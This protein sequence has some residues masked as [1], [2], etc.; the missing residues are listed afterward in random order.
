MNLVPN[1]TDIRNNILTQE[2]LPLKKLRPK[3]DRSENLFDI[4][5]NLPSA[6]ANPQPCF[7]ICMLHSFK[8]NCITCRRSQG[9]QDD[10]KAKFKL[11]YLLVIQSVNDII[12]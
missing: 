12:S 5:T 3:S 9:L 8:I 7:T 6:S 10:R 4:N 2:Q 11:K 1:S